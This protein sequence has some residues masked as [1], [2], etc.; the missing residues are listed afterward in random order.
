MRKRIGKICLLLFGHG[1]VFVMR[2]IVCFILFAYWLDCLWLKLRFH[3][4]LQTRIIPGKWLKQYQHEADA[5]QKPEGPFRYWDYVKRV[6]H[7]IDSDHTY[8]DEEISRKLPEYWQHFMLHFM[9]PPMLAHYFRAFLK[10][11]IRPEIEEDTKC[12]RP[13]EVPLPMYRKRV[14]R[15]ACKTRN[16][17]S[18]LLARGV[19]GSEYPTMWKH[20]LLVMDQIIEGYTNPHDTNG[21]AEA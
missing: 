3:W 1:F 17:Y 11:P 8:K 15:Q 16:L 2:S 18:Q 13:D 19:G 5:Y 7:D 12:L 4:A 14:F 6:T 9:Y 20:N 21:Q 10:C